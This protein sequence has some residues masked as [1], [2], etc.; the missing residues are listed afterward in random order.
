MI[1]LDTNVILR[2]FVTDDPKQ[3]HEAESLIDAFTPSDPGWIGVT[4]LAELVW[5]LTSIYRFN[6]EGVIGIV[7]TLLTSDDLMIEQSDDMRRAL[8][9]YRIGKADFADC[10]FAVTARAAGCSRTV[11]LDRIAAR[12]AGMELIA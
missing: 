12:D 9:L 2:Y 3:V 6:R 7:E 11:T 10:V 5:A 4:V 1:G 8:W